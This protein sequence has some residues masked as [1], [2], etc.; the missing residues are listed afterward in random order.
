VRT[1]WK[2]VLCCAVVAVGIGTGSEATAADCRSVVHIGDS[3]SYGAERQLQR[4]YEAAGFDDVLIDAVRGRLTIEQLFGTSSGIDALTE[5]RTSVEH[6]D[7]VVIALGTNDSML[8]T[9]L[10]T[11]ERIDLVLSMIPDTARVVW[12]DS[13][14]PGTN[15][16][17]WNSLLETNNGIDTVVRWSNY[18]TRPVFVADGFHLNFRGNR[19]FAA[20]IARAAR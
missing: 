3:L 14:R 12:V 11:H 19:T 1:F 16:L 10:L 6:A 8:P 18:S 7:V 20:L 2:V 4:A 5:R 15:F 9:S 13:Y 17:H